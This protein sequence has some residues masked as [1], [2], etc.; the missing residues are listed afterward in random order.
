[1]ICALLGA[2][3]GMDATAKL[4]GGISSR[5]QQPAD[6]QSR[7]PRRRRCSITGFDGLVPAYLAAASVRQCVPRAVWPG[8]D[9]KRRIA[10]PPRG[11]R[12][13]GCAGA[14]SGWCC[15]SSSPPTSRGTRLSHGVRLRLTSWSSLQGKLARPE[16]FEL[17]TPW[18]VARYS[19][20]AELRARGNGGD[21]RDLS[22]WRRVTRHAAG[23]RTDRAL[24]PGGEGGRLWI[25]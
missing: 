20:R 23:A 7:I 21:Y 11:L 9:R 19:I 24:S 4:T 16:R 13:A 17:P 25:F 12:V 22:A 8:L 14:G 15:W 6:G 5:A 10:Q 3:A 1:M 2:R 18:F